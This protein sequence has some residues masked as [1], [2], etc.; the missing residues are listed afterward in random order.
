MFNSLCCQHNWNLD[1]LFSPRNRLQCE[2]FLWGN[3]LR[4][5]YFL[6]SPFP[7]PKKSPNVLF[8]KVAQKSKS[9]LSSYIFSLFIWER[10]RLFIFFHFLMMILQVIITLCFCVASIWHMSCCYFS[11]MSRLTYNTE[12]MGDVIATVKS[13][14]PNTML[15]EAVIHPALCPI[16]F[17]KRSPNWA[18]DLPLLRA[19]QCLDIQVAISSLPRGF[20]P[21]A[22][23]TWQ[24]LPSMRLAFAS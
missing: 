14:L 21:W 16:A 23:R 1:N 4:E 11:G 17:F 22:P 6:P 2:L 10:E 8:K 24:I 5:R 13:F 3:F 7:E 20:F 15:A 12:S 18:I 19:R 9:P